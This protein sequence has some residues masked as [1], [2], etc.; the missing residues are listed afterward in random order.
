VRHN[1][2]TVSL[3]SGVDAK[4]VADRIE[5]ANMAYTLSIY[6]HRSTGRTSELP[7]PSPGFLLGTGGTC[8][9]CGA[10]CVSNPSEDGLCAACV[11]D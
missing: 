6:M 3:D 5:H 2:A 1:Y 11:V 4:I 10:A 8:R 9:E 7:K